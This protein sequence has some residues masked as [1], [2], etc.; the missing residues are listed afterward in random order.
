VIARGVE[1]FEVHYYLSE[2]S[3][4]KVNTPRR[5]ATSTMRRTFPPTPGLGGRLECRPRGDNEGAPQR[6]RSGQA[7]APTDASLRARLGCCARSA[8]ARRRDGPTRQRFRSRRATTGCARSWRA[9]RAGRRG[10]GAASAE[11]S[12]GARSLGRRL[13]E[14]VR[15]TLGGE[16]RL[17]EPSAP[18]EAV[19]PRRPEPPLRLQP[20]A[21]LLRQAAPRTR[22]RLRSP[23][24]SSRASLPPASGWP[25]RASGL[26][27]RP[28]RSPACC[29]ARF[30]GAAL[31]VVDVGEHV[32]PSG[33]S[34]GSTKREPRL[35]LAR[36]TSRSEAS[37]SAFA[38]YSRPIANSG[39]RLATSRKRE[40]ASCVRP[41]RCSSFARLK[42]ARYARRGP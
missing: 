4:R 12:G 39:A 42:A 2:H 41:A 30:R 7:A 29:C 20:G 19:P 25:R 21:I 16:K 23:S 14:L 6:L 35:R 36:R 32:W 22:G 27:A 38:R 33:A 10:A 18:S 24:R 17:A 11:G 5:A 3:R 34:A 28:I 31:P 26:H 8:A 40:S 9:A 37:S 13:L 15:M 1:S